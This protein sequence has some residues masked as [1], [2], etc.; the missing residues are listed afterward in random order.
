MLL[1]G[2]MMNSIHTKVFN[3]GNSQAVRL[4]KDFAYPTGTQLILTK[5]NDVVTIRPVQNLADVLPIFAK[6]GKQIGQIERME[7][8]DNQRN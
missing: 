6:I 1:H 2:E 7:F 8:E 5:E 3:A 4:P